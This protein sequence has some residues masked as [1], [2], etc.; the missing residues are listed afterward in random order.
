MK[1]INLNKSILDLE[2]NE[3]PKTNQGKLLA[4]AL[5]MSNG[6]KA[7]KHL[8]WA[9]E[10]WRGNVVKIDD[11]DFEDL[12]NFIDETQ[13]LTVLAKGQILKSMSEPEIKVVEKAG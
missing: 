8:D 5:I 11:E 6:G 7:I 1:T 3:I 2:L 4:N 12:R 10:F 9:L 13:T